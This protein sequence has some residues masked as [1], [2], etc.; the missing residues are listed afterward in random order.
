MN[1]LASIVFPRPRAR[2]L[3]DGEPVPSLEKSVQPGQAHEGVSDSCDRVCLSPGGDRDPEVDVVAFAHR[4]GRDLARGVTDLVKRLPRS[5]RN[6][7]RAARRPHL[8][9]QQQPRAEDGAI[10][11]AW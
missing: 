3:R 4:A 9:P 7:A 11:A 5:V 10:G 6:L 8:V 1:V 2:S